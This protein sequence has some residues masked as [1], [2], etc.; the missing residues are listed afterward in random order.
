L[1]KLLSFDSFVLELENFGL[2]ELNVGFFG[3][4]EMVKGGISGF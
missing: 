4:E 2:E 3:F 1:K